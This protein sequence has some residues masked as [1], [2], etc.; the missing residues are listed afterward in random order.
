MSNAPIQTQQIAIILVRPRYPENIGSAAR[1]MMN[2]GF[3][4]LILV[5]PLEPDQERMRKTAT[6]HAAGIIDTLTIHD[7][8]EEVLKPFTF[9]A[10]T[11]TRKGKKRHGLITPQSFVERVGTLSTDDKVAILFGSEDKG[12][13]N[14][15]L[16]FADALVSIPTMDFSSINLAQ[17]VMI[18]CYEL[19]RKPPAG[20]K[21]P[22]RLANKQ[23]IGKVHEAIENL[24]HAIDLHNPENPD[25]WAARFRNLLSRAGL[26][27]GDTSLVLDFIGK[28]LK[29][30][31][32]A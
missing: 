18:L 30:I 3:S 15:E 17:S 23:E 31:N 10:A 6:H 21:N 29:K 2:M 5:N 1:A 4:E 27:A 14:D 32:G 20:E 8:L 7:S 24:L 28:T 26:R 16:R 25:H 19:S 9:V 12:L 22:L 11:T 13:T